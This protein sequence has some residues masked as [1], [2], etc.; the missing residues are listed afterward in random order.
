M[1]IGT[2]FTL[3]VIPS[4]YVLLA[5]QH[6]GEDIPQRDQDLDQPEPVP[7]PARSVER[8]ERTV[9]SF[10]SKVSGMVQPDGAI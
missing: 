9:G 8:E 7:M 2:I 10:A 1:A 5:K 3:L 4:I 6:A